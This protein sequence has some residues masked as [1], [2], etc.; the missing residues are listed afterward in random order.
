MPTADC[1]PSRCRAG[2]YLTV[3]LALFLISMGIL[4]ASPADFGSRPTPVVEMVAARAQPG[5]QVVFLRSG[6][7]LAVGMAANG[8][9]EAEILMEAS[10]P[11]AAYTIFSPDG[12][13]VRSGSIDEAGWLVISFPT[14]V[15]GLYR[16]VVRTKSEAEDDEDFQLRA[17]VLPFATATRGERTRAEALYSK[18]EAQRNA[19]RASDV[20][21]AIAEYRQAASVWE[22]V[23]DREA[24]ALAL[25]GEALAWLELS[26][27]NN[28]I[29]TLDCAIAVSAASVYLRSW[30]LNLKAQVFLVR[31]DSRSASVVAAE[32]LRLGRSLGD[33]ELEAD[34]LTDQ[35]ASEW[36]THAESAA[37]DI[38]EALRLARKSGN[39]GTMALALRYKAWIQQDQGH[40]T[41]ALS[42][43]QQAEEYFRRVGDGRDV[44]QAMSDIANIEGLEG[45]R[46]SALLRNSRLVSPMMESGNTS[47][48]ATVVGNIG[49]DYI[50]LNRDRDAI[51]YLQKAVLAFRNIHD[52][53]GESIY[54]GQLCAVE[55]RQKQLSNALRDCRRS[56]SI[57]EQAHDPKRL[58][59]T[60]W[61][62]GK[63][64]QAFGQIDLAVEN[65]R[66]AASL[67]EQVPDP[68][69]ESQSLLD[70]GDVIEAAHKREEALPLFQRA[71]SLSERAEDSTVQLEARFRIARWH[72]NAGEDADAISEL[73]IALGQIER[74]R[75][76]VHNGELQA[77]Y[78]AAMRKCH[79]LYVD[80]LMR[81]HE[82]DRASPSDVQA[83]EVSE[84]AR[85]R[86]LLDSLK[87][88]DLDQPLNQGEDASIE[89][90]KLRIAVEQAYDQRLKL[91]LEGGRKRE[92]EE[93]SAMLTQAIDSLQRMEDVDRDDA[94]A[95]IPSRRPLTAKEILEAS[96]SA[97]ATLLEY[98]L[99]ADR[100]YLWVVHDGTINS[101]VLKSRQKEIESLV[102]RW[103][104]LA[105]TQVPREGDDAE[106]ELRSVAA[107]LSCILLSNYIEPQV[108][109]LVIVADGDLAM[110]PFASLPLNGC[111][112]TSGPPVITAHQ[113]VM[114]PSLSV[115]LTHPTPGVQAAFSRE[116]AIVANPVFDMSDS[117]VHFKQSDMRR[118]PF[119]AATVESYKDIPT[120]PRLIG[121]GEEATAI[122]QTVGPEKA[123]L[124]LGFNA[125]VETILSPAMRDYRV[126]H[127]ATHGVV[128]ESTPG[129]SGLVLSLVSSDG[130][131]VF[132]YLK[133]RDIANLDL[134]PELV[135]L[136]ACDSG[137][138]TNLSGEGVT[139]L[140]YA[141]LYAGARQVASTL[142]DVDDEVTKEMMITFY[143]EMYS[144]GRDPAEALRQSQI[145]MMKSTHRSAPYYW[146]GFEIT[147]VGN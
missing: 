96:R 21:E 78:L 83:L 44:L 147:S 26:Q 91:M 7:S 16:F 56:A 123:S 93:N 89:R 48:Y 104:K 40:L 95:M 2:V 20:H 122:Q 8:W 110:L 68:R 10:E 82:W 126:L 108:E 85:A 87:A 17:E 94:S 98:A 80:I 116:V 121:T 58:A 53:S 73:R 54:L 39:T 64:R 66:R 69:F 86:T 31:W 145:L 79:Q 107:K 51:P 4:S 115:F 46:Y 15:D 28:A 113:V 111:E 3:F 139:G 24:Q 138:G 100:S 1:L 102:R 55:L 25:S 57:I 84:S 62:L 118:S 119:S 128:D 92:L 34:A 74:K 81:E 37:R 99:G 124:F 12:R 13:E 137:A 5:R 135:V 33:A 30:L 52:D 63:V 67:S 29:A 65:Y 59:I 109:K 142:W 42:L 18:A 6:G 9:K 106:R 132:G 129:F 125:S 41:R 23:R 45:D 50:A 36:L 88:H 144:A 61:R 90:L 114:T 143:K 140:T 120:L 141:F 117:R 77:S 127:L 38:D 60:T 76:T 71:L 43:M 101:Y 11:R 105:A 72:A 32:A 27:Y 70:W 136:S 35:G 49:T 112:A 22:H 19:L 47:N 75:S 133:T 131:P 134:H 103:R 146:A 97:P 14:P 130:H